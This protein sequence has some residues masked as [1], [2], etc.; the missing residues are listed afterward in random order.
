MFLGGGVV[1][2]LVT[3]FV[4]TVKSIFCASRDVGCERLLMFT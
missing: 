3:I 4:S 2:S 1:K